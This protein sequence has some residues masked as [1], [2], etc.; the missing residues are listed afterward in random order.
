MQKAKKF[1][2]RDSYGDIVKKYNSTLECYEYLTTQNTALY[3]FT[4]ECTIDDLEVDCHEFMA[5]FKS[6]ETPI[7]LQFFQHERFFR[8]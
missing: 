3:N 7:D 8:Q 4:I 1:R 2:I 5:A 6:G